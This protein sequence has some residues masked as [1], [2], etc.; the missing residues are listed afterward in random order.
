MS[1]TVIVFSTY[2]ITP[3]R[4]FAFNKDSVSTP[5]LFTSERI[6]SFFWD[7]LKTNSFYLNNYLKKGLINQSRF[8]TET[9]AYTKEQIVCFLKERGV[10]TSAFEIDP[11]NT[12]A[13]NIALMKGGVSTEIVQAFKAQFPQIQEINTSVSLDGVTLEELFQNLKDTQPPF[14]ICNINKDDE[15]EPWLRHRFSY[16][17]LQPNE[18]SN[19]AIYAVWALGS[20]A[21]REDWVAALTEQFLQLNADVENLYLILHDK[22]FGMKS[23]SVIE[24]K[25]LVGNKY[26]RTVAVFAHV[27]EVGRRVV[28]KKGISAQEI[29]QQIIKI[30]EEEQ[31]RSFL[32]SLA[33]CLVEGAEEQ[34]LKTLVD[35]ANIDNAI[36]IQ[37][38]SAIDSVNKARQD[39][40]LFAT[41]VYNAIYEV[42][43]LIGA[44][45]NG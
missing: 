9:K 1:K 20:P 18:D 43:S 15:R 13:L 17:E 14:D 34:K 29:Y 21:K 42:N 23:F 31:K 44:L 38:N 39:E 22:D 11:M 40:Q 36:K 3:N 7:R 26:Y 6:K 41:S 32:L 28:G 27:D 4:E 19:I 45:D 10:D 16:Y 24:S 2:F 35:E 25:V 33:Q 8:D 5:S 12:K 30:V 37:V